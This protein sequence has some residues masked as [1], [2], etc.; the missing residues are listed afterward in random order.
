MAMAEP[1]PKRAF[2]EAVG[3]L[4]ARP[5]QVRAPLFEGHPFFDPLDKVQVKYEMLRAHAVEGQ[6]VVAVSEAFGFSRQTFYTTLRSFEE[7]GILGL[8]DEKRGRR[9]RVKLTEE[10]VAWIEALARDVPGLSGRQIAEHLFTE[11]GVEVHR[12]TVERLLAGGGKKNR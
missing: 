6:T 2:L 4:H 12:R 11:R 1:H 8:T 7:L 5:E 9:G 10:D 3:A